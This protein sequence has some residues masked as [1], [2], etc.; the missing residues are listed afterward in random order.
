MHRLENGN[1]TQVEKGKRVNKQKK[2][3]TKGVW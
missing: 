1:E 2:E 3:E